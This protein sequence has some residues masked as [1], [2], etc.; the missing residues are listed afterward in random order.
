MKS[1]VA[2]FFLLDLFQTQANG[3]D[4]TLTVIIREV[5]NNKG[6]VR[7]ALYK[8]E[9][10]FMKT[11]WQSKST[12]AKTGEVQTVFEDIPPGIYAI[13]AIH[14]AN[15]NDKLD[16]NALGIPKEGFGF[17]NNAVGMFG[18]PTFGEAKFVCV[19]QKKI[20]ITLKYY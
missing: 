17:S 20:E 13:S 12:K 3:Q 14:D 15:E 5:K 4:Q 18:P 6:V 9:K 19:G 7:V 16:S 2:F 10:E 1:L 8:T 11:M